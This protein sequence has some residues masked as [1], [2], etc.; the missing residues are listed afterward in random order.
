MVD[1]E[2]RGDGGAGLVLQCAP[3]ALDLV[4]AFVGE[5]GS[6]IAILAPM[7]AAAVHARNGRMGWA[8]GC[9]GDCVREV[10]HTLTRVTLKRRWQ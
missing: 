6:G 9:P 3:V 7:A 10:S 4:R 2:A 8:A 1:V 5:N